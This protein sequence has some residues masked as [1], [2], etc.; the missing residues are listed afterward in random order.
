MT[1]IINIKTSKYQ[2]PRSFRGV[3]VLMCLLVFASGCRSA[4]TTQ[5]SVALNTYQTARTMT[6]GNIGVRII[7]CSFGSSLGAKLEKPDFRLVNENAVMLNQGIDLEFGLGKG[8]DIGIMA[9][10]DAN[11]LDGSLVL[12]SYA[13]KRLT[14][15]TSSPLFS[16]L[17]GGEIISGSNSH[18][19]QIYYASLFNSGLEP[20]LEPNA[21]TPVVSSSESSLSSNAWR[22]FVSLPVNFAVT[23]TDD[24]IIQPGIHYYQQFIIGN[25]T[26]IIKRLENNVYSQTIVGTQQEQRHPLIIPSLSISIRGRENDFFI[27]PELTL[28]L[29]AGSIVWNLGMSLQL[30]KFHE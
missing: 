21:M 10:A 19:S 12:R 11:L 1:T 14:E 13:K 3:L 16:L 2:F 8:W 26:T 15:N 18:S 29:A 22:V 27:Q 23:S 7:G 30:G 6:A 5:A 24:V 9:R 25:T 17:W 4:V 28:A 20:I